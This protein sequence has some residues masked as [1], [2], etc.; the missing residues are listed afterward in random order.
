MHDIRQFGIPIDS[1]RKG[2]SVSL[3]QSRDKGVS[4]F[5]ADRPVAIAVTVIE[6]RLSHDTCPRDDTSYGAMMDWFRFPCRYQ[7]HL[8]FRKN[9][10]SEDAMS[11]ISSTRESA[12]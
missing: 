7:S 10:C 4:V 1:G 5:L 9:G 2:R 8:T 3:A 12:V 6:S 11:L